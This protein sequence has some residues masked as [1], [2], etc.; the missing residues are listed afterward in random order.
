[1]SPRTCIINYI[2]VREDTNP[3]DGLWPNGKPGNINLTILTNK[4]MD[5]KILFIIWDDIIFKKDKIEF[6]VKRLKTILLPVK[7]KGVLE[8]LNLLKDD[9]FNRLYSKKL[10]KLCFLQGELIQNKQ[11]SPG[12]PKL[13]DAIEL[14][15]EHYEIKVTKRK[16]GVV[17]HTDKLEKDELI[18]INEELLSRTEYLKHLAKII[19]PEFKLIPVLE[20]ANGKVEDSFLFRLRNKN[21]NILLIWENVN[22]SRA[23]YIFKFPERKQDQ[24]LKNIEDFI[25]T[26]DFEHKRSI[27]SSKS[28][29]SRKIKLE[30]CFYEKYAHK[31][32]S[33]FKAEVEY[34]I[35]YTV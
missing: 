20:Y 26:T 33:K 2:W 16:K 19:G 15:K 29:N 11:E 28:G 31:D 30:L 27:L 10:F 32:I 24:A 5:K 9:Y 17:R 23:T 18:E 35:G 21:G 1:V 12:W 4:M 6:D 22:V 3:G 14:I 25:S 8:S 34:L 7:I 13:F